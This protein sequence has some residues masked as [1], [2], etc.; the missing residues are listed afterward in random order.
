M[1]AK[2]AIRVLSWLVDYWDKNIPTAK[3]IH[4]HLN[5]MRACLVH[6]EI[7][8]I[9]FEKLR[10]DVNKFWAKDGQAH[11]IANKDVEEFL[12]VKIKQS[13]DQ[14]WVK[15]ESDSNVNHPKH[16]NS[17]P[18]GVE[19]IE[20]IRHM[21]YNPGACI[22]YLWRSG[23]KE[24]NPEPQEIGKAIWYLADEFLTMMLS[25]VSEDRIQS[26]ILKMIE[27]IK[28]TS[29]AVAERIKVGD[30]EGGHV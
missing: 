19:C 16:Y 8:F 29:G 23:L 24:A 10:D 25:D 26:D 1:T 27:E 11:E 4:A 15:V 12:E 28:S 20:V 18:S 30:W 3:E 9:E 17:H 21:R 5:H 2:G 7:D 14:R 22:K 6:E 13:P